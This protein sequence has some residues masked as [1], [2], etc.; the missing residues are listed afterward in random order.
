M[1]VGVPGS[2]K[3]TWRKLNYLQLQN[4]RLLS[5]DDYI[6]E[7]AKDQNMTYNE[8]FADAIGRATTAMESAIKDTIE[9]KQ[10]AIFDQTNV[11]KKSRAKKLKQFLSAGYNCE[12]YY[13]ESK[14]SLSEVN[15]LRPTK[16]IPSHIYYKMLHDLEVPSV[17]EGFDYVYHVRY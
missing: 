16:V 2:G 14:L 5:T 1:L 17:D 6:E 15:D 9:N 12:A 10:S 13:F 7:V 8:A 11:T 4:Y 3:S